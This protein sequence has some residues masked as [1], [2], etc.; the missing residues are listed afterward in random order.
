MKA[1]RVVKV[2]EPQKAAS[3]I[4]PLVE[5]MLEELGENPKREGFP[6]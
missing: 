6:S 5:R 2:M 1:N 3:S 4:A